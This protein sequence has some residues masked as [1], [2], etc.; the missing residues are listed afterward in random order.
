MHLM[1][2]RQHQTVPT[3]TA[4]MPANGMRQG[5]RAQWDRFRKLLT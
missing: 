2:E 3:V 5:E 1:D 4:V